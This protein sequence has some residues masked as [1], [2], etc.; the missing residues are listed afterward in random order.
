MAEVV[1]EELVVGELGVV[2]VVGGTEVV[3]EL[4]VG[5]VLVVVVT[6]L[7]ET[8]LDVGLTDVVV[9][10]EILIV[11]LVEELLVVVGGFELEVDTPLTWY[12][13]SRLEPPQYSVA[14]P[15]QVISQPEVAL[16]P[17]FWIELS[18]KH[19]LAYSTPAS[20]YLAALHALVH[21]AT[22]MALE[23]ALICCPYRSDLALTESV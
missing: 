4:E 18:Q 8:E 9:E 6:V 2:D 13:F 3:E 21:S 10:V 14:F 17:P 20:E 11:V 23:P 16:A 1:V 5:R 22:V 19:S 15:V 7:L 12:T